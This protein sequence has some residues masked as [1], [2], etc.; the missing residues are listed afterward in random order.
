M[1]LK[2]VETAPRVNTATNRQA[3]SDVLVCI[4]CFNC[5]DSIQQVLEPLLEHTQADILLVDD[6]SDEPLIGLI[7]Q[8]FSHC[9]HRIQVLNPKEKVFSGG[10]KN[11][12]LT[13][14]LEEAY[15]IVILM[16][17][18]IITS[19]TFVS[20]VVQYFRDNADAVV[21]APSILPSGRWCQYADTLINFSS[22][23]PERRRAVSGK[24]CLAGYAFG[25]NMDVFRQNP[26]FHLPRYGGEDVL[27]FHQI[28]RNF[29]LRHLPLLNS[30]PVWHVPPRSTLRQVLKAQQRYGRS[31]FVHVSGRR[32]ILF[33]W[34]P[35]LHLFTPRFWL[36]T[37]RLL[38]RQRFGDL[39][40]LPLCWCL[41]FARAVQILRL[42]LSGYRD[43]G[44]SS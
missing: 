14:G 3:R 5:Q 16:D 19:S 9:L 25:L 27:F 30:L 18:D 37:V 21:V 4:P 24:S 17:S 43:L 44:A 7:E 11:I 6:C 23:L 35:L 33:H 40:Y 42:R 13:R 1:K 32:E 38:R 10:A 41:D 20:R 34:L 2:P 12:G 28:K 39:L 29:A 8:R 15:R 31:F 26:C 22:Y 36:M